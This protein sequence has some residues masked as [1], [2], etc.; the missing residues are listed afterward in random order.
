MAGWTAMAKAK[1]AGQGETEH[2]RRETI[3]GQT[4]L[5]RSTSIEPEDGCNQ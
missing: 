2:A 5:V 3:Q 4:S 1:K